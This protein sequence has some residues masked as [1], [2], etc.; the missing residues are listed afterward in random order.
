MNF[1]N[2]GTQTRSCFLCLALFTLVILLCAC[3]GGTSDSTDNSS[4]RGSIAFKLVWKEHADLGSATVT[5]TVNPFRQ[6]RMACTTYGVTT[7][8]GDVYDASNTIVASAE[9]PCEDGAMTLTDIPSGIFWVLLEGKVGEAV[10]WRG[11]ATRIEVSAGTNTNAGTITMV[12]IVNDLDPPQVQPII[13]IVGASGV[14]LDTTMSAT[15]NED[16]HAATVGS[17]TCVLESEGVTVPSTVTYNSY[18]H[19]V[20]IEPLNQLSLDSDYSVTITTGVEDLAGNPLAV[21]TIWSFTTS[22]NYTITA[23]AATGG[24][25]VPSGSISI[26]PGANQ[27]FTITPDAD[28]FV[29]DLKVDDVSVGAVTSYTFTNVTSDHSILATFAA[30]FADLSVSMQDNP[31]P[32]T[33]GYQLTYTIT[34]DNLGTYPSLN[35]SLA[36]SVPTQI[37]DPEYSTDSGQNWGPWPGSVDLGTVPASGTSEVR[38]R[39]V[40]DPSATDAITNIATVSSDTHDSNSDNNT[41]EV[42]TQVQNVTGQGKEILI[43]HATKPLAFFGWYRASRMAPPGWDMF[44]RVVDWTNANRSPEDT[45]I[46]LFTYNG[47]LSTNDEDGAAIYHYL[48]NA[49]YNISTEDVH[50]QEQ[51]ENFPASYYADF[52]L[53]IY[54]HTYPRDATNVVSSGIPF[55]SICY[56]QTDDMGIGTGEGT[57][58]QYTAE[59]YVLNNTHDI[60]QPYALGQ[61]TFA[62]PMWTDATEVAGD[63]IAL[64]SNVE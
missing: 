55:I 6:A 14:P 42:S 30:N 62:G 5:Q 29:S 23:T 56:G 37:L 61:L 40:V 9:A 11:Q 3:G 7:I 2:S 57:M 39:G 43:V 60:T 58:H 25:I 49:G 63:G 64:V 24:S 21:D 16:V 4:D 41:A 32:V 35:V 26:N 34:V 59:F 46:I 53:A 18:T 13:P 50:H 15:F 22:P 31:D 48:G 27:T 20:S 38:I 19:T 47:S 10:E 33:A 28:Y 54:A 44:Q 36:D 17:S 45:D 8:H 52:D 12:D 1:L 51:I